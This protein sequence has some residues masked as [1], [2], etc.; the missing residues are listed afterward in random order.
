MINEK[1]RMLG[2]KRSAIRELFE[3]G[4]KRKREIG[5]EKVFDFSLG[6]PSVPAPV[7][8]GEGMRELLSEVDPILLFG[9]TS[10]Q[11]DAGVRADLADYI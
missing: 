7:E 9:Y 1:M 11:G 4:L 6:N 5:E 8:L 10:A 2:A 3:Y